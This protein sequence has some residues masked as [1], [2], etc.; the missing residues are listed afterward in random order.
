MLIDHTNGRVLDLLESREKADVIA[1]LA[2]HKAGLLASLQ[3]VTCDMWD[4][5]A[6]AAREVFGEAVRVTIDRFHVMKNFH[7]RFEE[8]RRAIQ[9]TLP[10]ER[11]EQ[12]KGSRWLWITNPEN[13]SAA[14]RKEL[15]MLQRKFPELAK[16]SRHRERLRRIFQDKR[17]HRPD[18]AARLAAR[19]V[20]ARPAAGADGAGAVL[21]DA[22]E[23]DGADRQLLRGPLEQRADGGV[24]PRPAGHPV[25]GL[26]DDQLR[27]LP[28]PGAP[29]I[30]VRP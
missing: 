5:Y 27:P 6:E 4:A 25:A 13:L 14:Q 28:P 30:R 21:P 18:T 2:S 19:L 16:L 26:R 22:G 11:A 24:Q 15:A 10:K 7:D 1:W 29:R 17:V 23:L 3:E 9:R 8:A 20:R 12:L